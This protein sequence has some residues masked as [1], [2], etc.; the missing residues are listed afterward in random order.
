MAKKLT[1]EE[2]I[3]RAVQI[4][5]NKYDY[6]K[7]FYIN[8]KTKVCIICTEH[9]EFWQTPINHLNGQGCSDC[10]KIDKFIK[11]SKNNFGEIYSFPY[12][13]NEYKNSHSKITIQC[14]KCGGIFTKI[15]GDHLTSVNGGCKKC[16][17]ID[18]KVYYTYKDLQKTTNF[19]LKYFTEKVCKNDLIT[20]ICKKHGEYSILVS[21]LLDG[22]GKCKK[23]YSY[24]DEKEKI[25]KEKAIQIITDKYGEKFII[26]FDEYVNYTTPITFIC[27]DCGYKT[28]RTPSSCINGN[29]KDCKQ[30]KIKENAFN[31]TKTNEEFIKE[32]KLLHGDKYDYSKTNYINSSQ[33]VDILCKEC[34]KYFTIEANSHLQGHGCPNHLTNKSQDEI[35]IVNYIKEI[36][37]GEIQTNQRNILNE[38]KELDIYLPEKQIAIEYNGVFWHNELN[39][40]DN[41]HLNKT[42][43]CNKKGIHLIHIFEDEWKNTQKQQIWKS[44]IKNQLGLIDEKIFARKCIIKEISKKEGYDFLEKNHIQGKCSSTVMIGLYYKNELVSLMTFGKSRHFIGNGKY[45]YELLRFCNKININ[46]IGG[47]SKLFK[48]FLKTYNPSNIVSYA[49]KRWSKGNLYEKLGFIKYN[50]SKP[51]YYYVINGKRKN[52]FNFRKSILIKKYNCPKDVSEKEFCKEQGWYRIYDCGCLCYKFEK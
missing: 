14:Q 8:N 5:G 37:K 49:D 16:L 12:I 40:H 41:Y 27:K 9:G 43:E 13:W 23:C 19:K 45:E 18:K 47:A 51:S 26:L 6:S 29:Y 7:V 44:M 17:L 39:K 33:K 3:E 50:E 20:L 42:I 24:N 30:C 31:K 22:R 48:H 11:Q 38:N 32:A 52:R 36:Y 10:L 4:H 15:A 34:N 46:V 28:K 25:K 35:N 21:T 2:F 1:T